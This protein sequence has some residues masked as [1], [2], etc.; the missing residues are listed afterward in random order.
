M[1]LPGMLNNIAGSSIYMSALSSTYSEGELSYHA[2]LH[3]G[4]CALFIVPSNSQIYAIDH[5][6]IIKMDSFYRNA[7]GEVFGE[8][9]KK[10]DT[11]EI[12]E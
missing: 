8:S 4:G 7:V 12:T 11:F 9:H 5:G 6:R 10:W 1:K 3:E 2:R